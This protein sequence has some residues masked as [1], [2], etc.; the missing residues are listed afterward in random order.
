MEIVSPLYCPGQSQTPGLKESSCLIVPKCWQDRCE[1]PHMAFYVLSKQVLVQKGCVASQAVSASLNHICNTIT[2][3][4][5]GVLLN[6]RASC[7][8]QN[9]AC[10]R[11]IECYIQKECYRIAN[12]YC[13]YIFSLCTCDINCPIGCHLQ[14][15]KYRSIKNFKGSQQGIKSPGFLLHAT[16]L[17]GH[18]S[19][20]LDQQTEHW[21][22]LLRNITCFHEPMSFSLLKNV[23][24]G[25]FSLFYNRIKK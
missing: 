20:G 21:L 16:A 3:N 18:P 15:V 7:D 11:H 5:L 9:C 12:I 8:L 19:A 14:K 25:Q 13:T 24:I 2:L 1:P 10:L 17:V 23:F 6:S 22:L 4:Q